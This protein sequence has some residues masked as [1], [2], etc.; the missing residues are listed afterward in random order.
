M[1][2]FKH[3][4][5]ATVDLPRSGCP[6]SAHTE[7]QVAVIEHCLTD[8]R[9]WTV[10]ELSTHS[11]ISELSVFH[12][13]RKDLKLRKLCAKWVTHPLGKVQKWTRYKTC[14]INLER[15]QHEGNDMLNR[16]IA[17]DEI[18]TQAYESELKRQSNEW[19]HHGSPQRHMFRQNP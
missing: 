16:I 6:E 19:H 4:H 11:G 18:W 9:C 5:V 10:A 1:K 2:A 13:L 15:F 17:T 14:H 12:I 7:V 3:G 8:K